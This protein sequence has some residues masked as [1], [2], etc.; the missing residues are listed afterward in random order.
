[1]NFFILHPSAFIFGKSPAT[2]CIVKFL[3]PLIAGGCRSLPLQH[4]CYFR[5]VSAQ[6]NNRLRYQ[7][8]LSRQKSEAPFMVSVGSNLYQMSRTQQGGSLY[9]RNAALVTR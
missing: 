5:S 2:P 1:M 9:Y 8:T 6:E 3:N 7:P 4:D